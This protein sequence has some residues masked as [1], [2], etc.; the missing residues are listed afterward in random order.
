MLCCVALC[1]HQWLLSFVHKIHNIKEP[2]TLLG[3]LYREIP[4]SHTIDN[5][6][7]QNKTKQTREK[8]L[9][10]KTQ[11]NQRPNNSKKT[12][13]RKSKTNDGHRHFKKKF[14]ETDEMLSH[15]FHWHFFAWRLVCECALVVIAP[16]GGGDWRSVS[17][18][19]GRTFFLARRK[20]SSFFHFLKNVV[21]FH[22]CYHHCHH[23]HHHQKELFVCEL[24]S[25]LRGRRHIHSHFTDDFYCCC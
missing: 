2:W 13:Q 18:Y 11:L 12:T 7:K 5:T 10:S 8:K 4:L 15:A 6:A 24:L 21:V 23:Q 20:S 1:G 22:F 16:G 25:C 19:D 9:W 17:F 14:Q 3:H